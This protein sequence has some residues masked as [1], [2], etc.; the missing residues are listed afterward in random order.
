MIQSLFKSLF[1][2][3]IIELLISMVLG[4]RNKED[5]KVIICANICTNPVIVYI[6]NCI[7]LLNNMILYSVVVIFLEIIVVI[8]EYIIYKKCLRCDKISPFII[9]LVNNMISF[10]MGIIIKIIK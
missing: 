10:G 3:L 4:S 8:V 1:F 9:S 5:I 2:T 7:M 6:T